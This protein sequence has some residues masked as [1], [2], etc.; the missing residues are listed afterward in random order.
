[1]RT[2]QEKIATSRQLIGWTIIII[3]ALVVL[4]FMY[5]WITGN[6]ATVTKST[7]VSIIANIMGIGV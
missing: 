1:M 3:L 6:F 5:L 7:A 2:L 4:I